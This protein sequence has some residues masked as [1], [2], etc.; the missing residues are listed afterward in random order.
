MGIISSPE[1]LDDFSELWKNRKGTLPDLGSEDQIRFGSHVCLPA[2]T[3]SVVSSTDIDQL[4]GLYSEA[5]DQHHG[6]TS[7]PRSRRGRRPSR[8]VPPPLLPSAHWFR[9]SRWGPRSQASPRQYRAQVSLYLR[10]RLHTF[11][12]ASCEDLGGD[13]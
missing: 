10:V 2:Y 7:R 4:K 13:Q 9:K 12:S 8:A 6:D 11:R 3:V 5:R 1:K